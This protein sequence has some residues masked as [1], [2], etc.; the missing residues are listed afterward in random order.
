MTDLDK[1]QIFI[2]K[3][4]GTNEMISTKQTQHGKFVS[5]FPDL[6]SISS[7]NTTSGMIFTVPNENNSNS[8][9]FD[10]KPKVEDNGPSL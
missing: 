4:M 1:I 7:G 2:D 3:L 5:L 6:P 8:F 10:N 9:T